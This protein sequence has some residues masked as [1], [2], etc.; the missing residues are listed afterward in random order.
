MTLDFIP[1]NNIDL[2]PIYECLFELF[3]VYLCIRTGS[4]GPRGPQGHPG[5]PGLPSDQGSVGLPGPP[6]RYGPPGTN[7][8]V[9]IQEFRC[10][11]IV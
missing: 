1:T 5:L 8:V 11:H 3:C 6:G 4:P 7:I 10:V 2:F 9:S